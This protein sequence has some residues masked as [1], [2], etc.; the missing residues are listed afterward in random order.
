ML[1]SRGP[2]GGSRV[3]KMLPGCRSAQTP[4]TNQHSLASQ[5]GNPDHLESTTFWTAGAPL[6][7]PGLP[8]CCPDA[9]LHTHQHTAPINTLWNHAQVI[10][11]NQNPLYCKTGEGRGG[12][13]QHHQDVVLVQAYT[14]VNVPLTGYVIQRTHCAC[15]P[16]CS[17]MAASTCGFSTTQSVMSKVPCL[18]NYTPTRPTQSESLSRASHQTSFMRA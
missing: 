18:T 12:V 14:C 1:D 17:P 2:G 9:G 13:S 16:M 5:S 3:T 4:H 6:G 10:L 15:W 11:N 7:G 8:G